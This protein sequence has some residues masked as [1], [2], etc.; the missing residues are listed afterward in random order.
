MI[1][2]PTFTLWLEF[3]QYADGYPR[4]DDDP[5]VDFC[6]AMVTLPDGREYCFTLWTF[7][8]LGWVEQHSDADERLVIP[9]EFVRAPD[10]FVRRLERPLIE[11]A[12]SELLSD[13]V[14]SE[15]LARPVE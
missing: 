4:G 6:N 14:P 7:R 2:A 5:E 13:G 15:W 8:Y 9:R 3:E 10:L 11:R 12:F 1:K